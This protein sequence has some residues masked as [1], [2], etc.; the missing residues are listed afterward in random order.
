MVMRIRFNRG[1][2]EV[3]ST[4]YGFMEK[5]Y[6]ELETLAR[7]FCAKASV[8]HHLAAGRCVPPGS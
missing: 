4:S 2:E 5:F 6:G 8:S 1:G 7:F 3:S